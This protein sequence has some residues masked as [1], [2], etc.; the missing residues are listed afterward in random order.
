MLHW[1]RPVS[2]THWELASW[3]HDDGVHWVAAVIELKEIVTSDLIKT[4]WVQRSWIK[5]VVVGW[6]VAGIVTTVWFND[7]TTVERT[8]LYALGDE[9]KRTSMVQACGAVWGHSHEIVI[10]EPA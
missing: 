2:W 6:V 8:M 4:A 5:A 1:H 10:E 7:E 3:V 9:K